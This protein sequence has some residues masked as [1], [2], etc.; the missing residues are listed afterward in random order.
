MNRPN[1]LA[2]VAT[3]SKTDPGTWDIAI[4]GFLDNFYSRSERRQAM[5]DPEPDL[6]GDLIVDATIGAIGE[7]LARRW[8]LGIPPWTEH[9]A[10]F[11]KRAHFPAPFEHLKPMLIAQSPLAFR[12]RL[13]FTEHEPLRR[14]R[15]PLT[16]S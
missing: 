14:A 12:R 7:H 6:T 11:L 13:L 16:V 9:P 5:L 8:H 3:R 4:A 10:R 2:D 15:M 1:T